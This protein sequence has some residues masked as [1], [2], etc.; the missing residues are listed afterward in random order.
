MIVVIGRVKACT[1]S[2]CFG[3]LYRLAGLEL[4]QR[5]LKFHGCVG[6]IPNLCMACEWMEMIFKLVSS[7]IGALLYPFQ[8]ICMD[9]G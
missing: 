1:N 2:A 3:I 5:N 8:L 4:V 7:L 9:L 6:S